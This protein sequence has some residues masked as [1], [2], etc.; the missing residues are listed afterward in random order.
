VKPNF[1]WWC[2]CINV[3]IVLLLYSYIYY[4]FCTVV[5]VVVSITAST[6]NNNDAFIFIVDKPQL[7]QIQSNNKLPHRTALYTWTQRTSCNTTRHNIQALAWAIGCYEERQFYHN[8][9]N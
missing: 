4:I 5:I 1:K 9:I 7:L 2:T 8:A 6:S 3:T